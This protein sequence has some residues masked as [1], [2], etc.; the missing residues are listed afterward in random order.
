MAVGGGL[1]G[2][3]GIAWSPASIQCLPFLAIGLGVNDMFVL[4]LALAEHGQM[5]AYQEGPVES[6]AAILSH[7]GLGV[8]LTSV[9]N[10]FAFGIGALI[11]VMGVADFCLGASCVAAANFFI[12]MTVFACFLYADC[13]RMIAKMVDPSCVTCLCQQSAS[14]KKELDELDDKSWGLSFQDLIAKYYVPLVMNPIFAIA[15]LIVSLGVLIGNIVAVANMTMGIE[16][17]DLV[18]SDSP[19]YKGIMVVSEHVST[20][21][22]LMI[23]HQLNI[24]AHQIDILNVLGEIT[25]PTSNPPSELR[26]NTSPP[27]L[28]MFYNVFV[29]MQMPLAPAPPAVA[30]AMGNPS[31]TM[32]DLG[33][34]FVPDQGSHP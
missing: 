16:I 22:V 33:Y 7:G 18:S 12:V 14:C 30:A 19:K 4:I 21:T 11:P 13:K 26:S 15:V 8:T 23:Y 1:I 29:A 31:L 3:A 6:L 5:R 25:S 24:P 27:W 32:A 10:T 17:S 34:T 20:W 28:S 2:W 9:A